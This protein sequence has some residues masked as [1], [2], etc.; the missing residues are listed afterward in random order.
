MAYKDADVEN[1]HQL[2]APHVAAL[3]ASPLAERRASVETTMGPIP[4]AAG[5]VTESLELSGVPAERIT[6]AGAVPGKVLL[7]LHGGG[8]YA[9]S[10][11]SYRHVVSRFAVAAQVTAYHLDYRLTPEHP[12]PAARDDVM[13]AYKQLL[14]DGIAPADLVVGGDSAGGNL[15]VSLLLK[16]REEGLPQ[17]AGLYLLSPWL[18]LTAS[19]ESYDRVGARDLIISR[20]DVIPL[21]RIYLGGKPDNPFTSPA[22]ADPAGL[23]PMLMQVGSEEALL[24]DSLN[25]ASRAAMAG[26]DVKLH[27]WPEMPHAWPLFHSFIRAG[28]AAID[29]AG[30]WMQL[31]LGR[32]RSDPPTA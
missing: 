8:F 13:A 21:A 27:V 17:P 19:G 15:A 2:F 6:H 5:C 26:V 18:D 3:R 14:A 9:G 28:L 22:R 4:L 7:H 25:F 23:P 24:S 11:K 12:F 1:F 30:Q 16:A 10:I 32:A 31:C 20:E 29:E